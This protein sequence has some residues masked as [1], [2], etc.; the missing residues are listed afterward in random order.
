MAYQCCVGVANEHMAW[1]VIVDILLNCPELRRQHN[2][3]PD[4]FSMNKVPFKKYNLDSKR[5]F[6]T[7]AQRGF[8]QISQQIPDHLLQKLRK[9]YDGWWFIDKDCKE[10]DLSE[11]EEEEEEEQEE[12]DTHRK[13]LLAHQE[14]T[15]DQQ[16]PEKKPK[17]S[18]EEKP[19]KLWDN[20]MEETYAK[21]FW[22]W[23]RRKS[24]P[25]PQIASPNIPMLKMI[26]SSLKLSPS[27]IGWPLKFIPF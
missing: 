23:A 17:Q 12:L 5:E 4:M 20:A 10:Y 19:K 14:P 6:C 13:R 16:K 18:D 15:E 3:F 22:S 9:Q 1:E 8:D 27:K 25:K 11:E 7:A 2:L 24:C 26:K 21:P